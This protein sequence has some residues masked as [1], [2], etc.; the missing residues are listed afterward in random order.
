VQQNFFSS[1]PD[2]WANSN[3]KNPTFAVSDIFIL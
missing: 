3:F 2:I 1:F